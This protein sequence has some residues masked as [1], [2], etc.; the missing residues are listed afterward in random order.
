M[1]K[2]TGF[3]VVLVLGFLVMLGCS[4]AS[5]ADLQVSS[6]ER[7]TN[8]D[9]HALWGYYSLIIDPSVP[10]VEVIPLRDVE[11][12]FNVKPYVNPPNCSDCIKITPTGPFKDHV[13]PLNITLKNPEMIKGYDV[14]GI[15]ISDDEGVSLVNPDS[16]TSLFDDGG[17]VTINPF[18]AYAKSETDRGFGPGKSFTEHYD[19]Y[20]SKFGKVTKISYAIDASWPSRAKEPYEINFPVNIGDLDP[21]GAD[22]VYIG[23]GVLAAGDDVIQVKLNCSSLGFP[24]EISLEYSGGVVWGTFLKNT[25]H[26]GPG[27]YSCLVSATAASSNKKLYNYLVLSVV[28]ETPISLQ[29]DVQPIYDNYCIECHKGPSPPVGLDLTVGNAYSNTVN[30]TA[31]ESSTKLIKPGQP[32]LSY[33]LAKILGNYLANPPFGGTGDRMPPGGPPWV[34]PL[35]AKLIAD[36]ITEGALNN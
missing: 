5:P 27:D 13:L 14:R 19:L 8:L 33:L 1:L 12:H 35:E 34:D 25:Y 28:G 24:E 22:S 23:V 16:Y 11:K 26:A 20:L 36:W 10:S 31:A 9:G 30:V 32:N 17:T 7:D 6:P 29:N 18:K 3:V 15:V 4:Q 2:L 21:D